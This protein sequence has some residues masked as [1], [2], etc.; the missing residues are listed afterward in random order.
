MPPQIEKRKQEELSEAIKKMTV[1]DD[2]DLDSG[3]RLDKF[4]QVCRTQCNWPAQH[5]QF[6][7]ERAALPKMPA[8]ET[9]AEAERLEVRDK[10][11]CAMPRGSHHRVCHCGRRPWCWPRSCSTPRQTWSRA[12]SRM[13]PCSSA[14]VAS[15]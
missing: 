6:V 13:P 2:V 7:R 3:E 15:P 5:W 14:C 9:V 12:S 8:K 11:C 4:R 10:V 1:D